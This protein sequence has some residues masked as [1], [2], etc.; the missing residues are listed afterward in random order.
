[1]ATLDAMRRAVAGLAVRPD[2]AEIDGND[3]PEGLCCQGRAI[4]DGDALVPSISAASIIAKVARD[5]LMMRLGGEYPAMASS[6]IWA[7]ARPS[8][9][10]PSRAWPDAASPPPSA[11]VKGFRSGRGSMFSPCVRVPKRHGFFRAG[12]RSPLPN[13]AMLGGVK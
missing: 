1:M 7:M 6:A 11:S 4:I 13:R 5:R 8:I 2:A 10:P 3:V 9:A 12:Q